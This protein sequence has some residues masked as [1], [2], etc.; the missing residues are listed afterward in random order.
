[1]VHL[2]AY[3]GIAGI[4]GGCSFILLVVSLLDYREK[5]R[6]SD[7]VSARNSLLTLLLS[8]VW[9]IMLLIAI[10]S[11]FWYAVRVSLGKD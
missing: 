7:R 1:M 5:G 4:V 6:E 11:F 8:P 9:P 10:A 2:Q 3:L